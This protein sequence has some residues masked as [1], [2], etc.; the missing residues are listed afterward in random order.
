[1]V[2]GN[3]CLGGELLEKKDIPVRK[4]SDLFAHDNESPKHLFS[5][6]KR[7]SQVAAKTHS[8]QTCSFRNGCFLFPGVANAERLSVLQNPSGPP[9]TLKDGHLIRREFHSRYS[10]EL[11]ETVRPA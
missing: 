4:V 7:D 1:M 11:K 10:T 9:V 2:D 6:H 8:V 5:R 3:G